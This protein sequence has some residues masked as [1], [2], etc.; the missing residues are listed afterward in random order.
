MQVYYETDVSSYLLQ[1]GKTKLN[2]FNLFRKSK[3]AAIFC[4]TDI[5]VNIAGT[6]LMVGSF[7]WGILL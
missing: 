7:L 3:R 1:V 5:R 6:A 4:M 2:K